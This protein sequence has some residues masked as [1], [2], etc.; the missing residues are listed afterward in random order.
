MGAAAA[1]AQ[2][3]PLYALTVLVLENIAAEG[4]VPVEPPFEEVESDEDEA[5][6]E[7][8]LQESQKR[9]RD[10]WDA[11]RPHRVEVTVDNPT[12][13]AAGGGAGGA[14][15]VKCFADRAAAVAEAYTALRLS[16]ANAVSTREVASSP[17]VWVEG[18][19]TKLFDPSSALNAMHT[20]AHKVKTVRLKQPEMRFVSDDVREACVWTGLLQQLPRAKELLDQALRHCSS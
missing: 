10:K 11:L 12:N 4:V 16:A 3:H 17:L 8:G 7:I 2:Q 9:K 14:L 6:V 5:P 15:R 20:C 13:G 1:A 19:A 18:A